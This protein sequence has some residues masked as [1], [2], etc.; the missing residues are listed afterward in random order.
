MAYLDTSVLAA[1]YCP[2]PLSDRVQEKLSRID[3]PVI[4]PLVDLELHSALSIKVR[5]GQMTAPLANRVATAFATHLAEGR[6]GLLA[7]GADE[8]ALARRWISGF[9]MPLRTLDALHLAV[10]F[11]NGLVLVTADRDL[12]RCAEQVG[13]VLELIT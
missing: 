10:A 13:V 9:S 1:Y 8:Y 5:S 2:E 4:S 6:Y 11:S 12:G 3:E 7:I